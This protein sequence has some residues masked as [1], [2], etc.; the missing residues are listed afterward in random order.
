MRLVNSPVKLIGRE[1]FIE[2]SKGSKYAYMYGDMQQV[3]DG[4]TLHGSVSIIATGKWS[5][6]AVDVH[7]REKKTV[8][9]SERKVVADFE[10]QHTGISPRPFTKIER[11]TR[12]D[13]R[14]NYCLVI[15]AMIIGKPKT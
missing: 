9:F 12:N 4:E 14:T 5:G 6:V 1:E 13:P 11:L 3:E 7:N 8:P 2:R 15:G 10:L